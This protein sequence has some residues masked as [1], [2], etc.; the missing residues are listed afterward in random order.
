MIAFNS[1]KK[2]G[3]VVLGRQMKLTND[4]S[5]RKDQRDR[6]K[7]LVEATQDMD[8]IQTAPPRIL[9]KRGASAWRSIIKELQSNGF[10]KQL[11]KDI[12]IMLCQQISVRDQAF[13]DVKNN[14]LNFII[15]DDGG[16]VKNVRKNPSLQALSD[17][18]NRIQSLAN[19]LGLTPSSRASLLNISG[20]D[21]DE[22]FSLS[23]M[24]KAFGV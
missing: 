16:N 3:V 18:T 19:E 20:N 21:K 1:K 2:G 24:K 12:L 7:E 22:S 6:T 23:D 8:T 4:P 15:K 14:G 10:V 9:D 5:D 17:S 11:D 13:E